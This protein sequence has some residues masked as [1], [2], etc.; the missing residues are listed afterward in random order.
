V[1]WAEGPQLA[2]R[3]GRWKLVIDGITYDRTEEGRKPLA[4][5][6]SVFLS[7]LEEDPGETRNLRRRH[8]ELVDELA[9]L[10]H[11]WRQAV[12]AR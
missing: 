10:A 3:R 5:E 8:P 6:D 1:F 4:G 2:V 12:G 11:R 7:N 9:T